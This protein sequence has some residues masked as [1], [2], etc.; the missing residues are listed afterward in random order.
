[1]YPLSFVNAS[2]D[3]GLNLRASSHFPACFQTLTLSWYSP[4]TSRSVEAISPTVA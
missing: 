3:P 1:M 4:N 2:R